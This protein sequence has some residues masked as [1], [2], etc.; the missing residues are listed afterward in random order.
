[1]SDAIGSAAAGGDRFEKA[2]SL[3]TQYGDDIVGGDHSRELLF[4]IH[5]G[6]GQKVV[7]IEQLGYTVLPLTDGHLNERFDGERV[8]RRRPLLQKEA[9]QRDRSPEMI[10]GVDKKQ[11]VQIFEQ[12]L[13]GL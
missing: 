3:L 11:R 1:M 4:L 13:V 5:H 7:L 9:R 2:R 8:E 10:R 6:K 12:L